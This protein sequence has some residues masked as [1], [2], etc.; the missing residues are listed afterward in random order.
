MKLHIYI[1]TSL[2]A[3][4]RYILTHNCF[5]LPGY[6]FNVQCVRGFISFQ[7]AQDQRTLES[8]LCLILDFKILA[9]RLTNTDLLRGR[10]LPVNFEK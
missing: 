10:G 9:I 6:V 5:I 4:T 7:L 1:I 3:R 8:Q 2:T